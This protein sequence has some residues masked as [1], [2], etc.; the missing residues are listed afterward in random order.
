MQRFA[1]RIALLTV[2][3]FALSIAAAGCNLKDI[4]NI[5]LGEYGQTVTVDK[6]DLGKSI[7][8]QWGKFKFS[9]KQVAKIKKLKKIKKK[10][11]A[12]KNTYT[13]TKKIKGKRVQMA[14]VYLGSSQYQIGMMAL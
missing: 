4:S 2:L 8:T 11:D 3:L 10:S 12:K 7:T 6:N 13:L 9:S 14:V 1:R 5:K